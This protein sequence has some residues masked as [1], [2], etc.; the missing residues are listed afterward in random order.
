VEQFWLLHKIHFEYW[1]TPYLS[2][3]TKT[4]IIGMV[5]A[6]LGYKFNEFY[7]SNDIRVYKIEELYDIKISIQSLFDLKVKESFLILIMGMTKKTC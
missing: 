2:N 3:S 7:E 4:A 1:R 5:G 6:V